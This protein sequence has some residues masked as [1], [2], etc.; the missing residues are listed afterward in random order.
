MGRLLAPM[1][2]STY[3]WR[4]LDLEG[5]SFVRVEEGDDLVRVAGHEICVEG[6]EAWSTRFTIE[7]NGRWEHDWTAIEVTAAGG[8][9]DLRLEGLRDRDYDVVDIAGNPFTNALV[10]RSHDVPVGGEIQVR[11]AFVETPALTVRPLTQRYR[12]LAA[13]RWEYADDEYGA[14]EIT[15]DPD[16]VAVDYQRLATRLG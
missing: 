12:R 11:A 13:D 16:R 6:V 8:T 1:R 15:V 10:L 4:R 5:I 9:D 14:F 2:V 3:A 7:L